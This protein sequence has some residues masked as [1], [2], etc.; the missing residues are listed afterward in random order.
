MTME[1]HV[2]RKPL[3]FTETRRKQLELY[4]SGFTFLRRLKWNANNSFVTFLIDALPFK[5]VTASNRSVDMTKV[6][7]FS[8]R[9]RWGWVINA[10]AFHLSC[11]SIIKAIRTICDLMDKYDT[12]ET[13][14][15]MKEI[16]NR[17]N[18]DPTTLKHK[19]FE[20]NGEV[21][22][23]IPESETEKC[24]MMVKELTDK[25]I[26]ELCVVSDRYGATYYIIKTMAFAV[27]ADTLSGL[28]PRDECFSIWSS[29][30]NEYPVDY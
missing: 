26:E 6:V 10:Y 15:K 4:L 7:Y 18:L 30:K 3:V 20:V 9:P 24:N 22:L 11:P 1:K 19:C 12:T 27:F 14:N 28:G 13:Y 29:L 21:I 16:A 2:E 8:D 5:V 17:Y 23:D 25:T